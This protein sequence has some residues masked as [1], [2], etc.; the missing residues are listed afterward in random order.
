MNDG[1]IVA[2]ATVATPIVGGVL[3][4]VLY[5]FGW[6]QLQLSQRKPGRPSYL[7][8]ALGVAAA[9]IGNGLVALGQTPWV[10]LGLG[11]VAVLWAHGWYRAGLREAWAEHLDGER[12]D[13]V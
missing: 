13:W 5:G 1:Q 11:G 7:L 10:L 6:T 3:A 12:G 9:L 2:A 4:W 8:I